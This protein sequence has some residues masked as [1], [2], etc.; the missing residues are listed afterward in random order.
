MLGERRA[1]AQKAL[2]GQS[3]SIAQ[4]CTHAA[5]TVLTASRPRAERLRTCRSG[6]CS[7][8]PLCRLRSRAIRRRTT[9]CGA[10]SPS[11]SQSSRPRLRA[12]DGSPEQAA[13]STSRLDNRTP[14][15]GGSFAG[16]FAGSFGGSFG[17][18]SRTV[19]PDE[20]PPAP[21][22]PAQPG[23]GGVRR[24]PER[25]WR[26]SPAGTGKSRRIDVVLGLQV[27]LTDR[28]ETLLGW[29]S[30]TAS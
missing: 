15:P 2:R 6:L 27:R 11:A 16:S 1:S 22:S 7:R 28:D 19:P 4:H 29:R 20:P 30:I 23:R 25:P 14:P 18:S 5:A 21:N 12:S 17:G 24:G 10:S 8:S 3:P 26:V 9:P 13:R